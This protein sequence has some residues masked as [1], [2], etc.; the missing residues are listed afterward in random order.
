MHHAAECLDSL[1]L[2]IQHASVCPSVPH[3]HR[4]HDS[5]AWFR[6]SQIR[7]GSRGMGSCKGFM[8]HLRG[9]LHF[10]VFPSY[11]NLLN[12]YLKTL[13]YISLML[14]HQTLPLSSQ[15]WTTSTRSSWRQ[16]LAM[17]SSGPRYVQRSSSGRMPSTVTIA[18]LINRMCIG[19]PWVSFFYILHV[20]VN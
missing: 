14:G 20:K 8:Q 18:K 10:L 4:L 7:T 11:L 16:L 2:D 3:G 1:E 5:D 15:Q 13:L 19:L 12:R 17:S 9:V 6:P